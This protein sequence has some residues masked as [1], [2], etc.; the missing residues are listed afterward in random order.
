MCVSAENSPKQQV[1]NPP[2]LRK[3]PATRVH[4]AIACATPRVTLLERVVDFMDTY[5]GN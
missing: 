4:E 1:A 2:E 3:K 5:N